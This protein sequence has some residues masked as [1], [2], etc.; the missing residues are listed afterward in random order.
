MLG[1][2]SG[3][4]DQIVRI[5]AGG[6][7]LDTRQGFQLVRLAGGVLQPVA[8]SPM[9]PELA[10]NVLLPPDCEATGIEIVPSVPETIRLSA[11]LMPCP[12]P[13]TVGDGG[14][15][16]AGTM[17]PAIHRAD[18]PYPGT[19]ARLTGQGCMAGYRFASVAVSPVQYIE[20]EQALLHYPSLEIRIKTRSTAPGPKPAASRNQAFRRMAGNMAANP[21][22]LARYASG[23][24]GRPAGPVTLAPPGPDDPYDYLI[25]TSARLAPALAPL[26]RWK[27]EKG[28]RTRIVLADSIAA[29]FPGADPAERVRACI[30]RERERCGISW[31]LLAG[32]IDDVPHR[33]AA[34]YPG[35]LYYSDLDG[36]WNLDGDGT[37]GEPEDGVDLYPD[38][39]VGRLPAADTI[40][41]GNAVRKIIAYERADSA[42]YQTKLLFIGA[43]LDAQTPTGQ[44]K[45]SIDAWNVAAYPNL[46]VEKLYPTTPIALGRSSVL[47]ALNNGRNLVNFS[48]HADYY[49]MGTGLRTGGGQIY[50]SD[51][52]GLRN[53]GRPAVLYAIGCYNGAFDRSCIGERF[54]SSANGAAA[55]IGCSRE[56]WFIPGLPLDGVSYRYDRAFFQALLDDSCHRLGEALAMAKALLVPSSGD[57]LMRWSQYEIN[58]LG[59]PEMPV[60]TDSVRALMLALPE[61]LVTG[62]DTI[63][64]AV[65]DSVSGQ[66]MGGATVCLSANSGAY[67]VG[68]SDAAGLARFFHDPAMADT[69][70]V[71]VT[72][73]NYRPRQTG[74]PVRPAQRHLAIAGVRVDDG[75]GNGDGVVNPGESFELALL[76]TNDGTV[77][78]DSLWLDVASHDPALACTAYA[79]VTHQ[80]LAPGDSVW[81]SA[82]PRAVV[83]ADCRDGHRVEFVVV[84]RTGHQ[85]RDSV[86]LTARGDSLALEHYALV[87]AVGDGDG[88]AED[89]ETIEL[90]AVRVGNLGSGRA[91]S[92]GSRLVP[93]SSGVEMLADSVAT[94]TV[95]PY[96]G[97][98]AAGAFRFAL[99]APGPYRF[100]MTMTGR[101]GRQWTG[102]FTLQ[103]R[104]TAPA[105]PTVATHRGGLKVEWPPTAGAVGHAV[106]RAFDDTAAGAEITPLL[107]GNSAYFVDHR[108]DPAMAGR[109]RIALADSSRCLSQLSAAASNL[110]AAGVAAGWPR[111]FG[112][113][114]GWNWNSPAAGDLDGDGYREVVMADPAGVLQAWDRAGTPLPGWPRPFPPSIN[115]P[116]ALADLDGDQALE[117]LVAHGDALSAVGGDGGEL[118]GWPHNAGAPLAAPVVCDLDRDGR[119]EVLAACGGDQVLALRWDGA[120]VTELWRWTLPIGTGP[121]LSVGNVRGGSLPEIIV[122]SWAYEGSRGY[123]LDGQGTAV[124][125]FWSPA[126]GDNAMPA[127]ALL[128]DLDGDDANEI[129][130]SFLVGGA[131][132]AWR[133]DGTP[134]WRAVPGTAWGTPAGV[135]VDGSPR[136]VATTLE[137][138]VHHL[139]NA[140]SAV[141]GWPA[142]WRAMHAAPAVSDLDGD[143]RGDLLLR[144][145]YG[146]ITALAAAGGT[147]P[148]FPIAT[149]DG[150]YSPVTVARL[151]PGSVGGL[152]ADTRAGDV[153]LWPAGGP[154]AGPADWPVQGHDVHRGN[155]H[156]ALVDWCG[157][158]PRSLTI[159]GDNF[160]CG[161]VVVDSGATV[162]VRSGA[163]LYF[164]DRRDFDDLGDDPQRAELVVRGRLVVAGTADDSVY[165]DT[166]SGTPCDSS[167]HG[168]RVEPGGSAELAHCGIRHSLRGLY[169]AGAAGN[170][171]T[172]AATAGYRL[173]P[174][175]P[176]PFARRTAI[177]FQL[178][179]AGKVE[180]SVYNIAGQRVR[181]LVDGSLAA[182]AHTVTW[183]GND[184][185]GATAS[186]GVYVVR[187]KVGSYCDVRKIVLLR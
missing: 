132:C 99:T 13:A 133:G 65:R 162:T 140:G 127:P 94:G 113:A 75:T 45:D 122:T 56:A 153:F 29:A 100:R 39:F 135:T 62:P 12:A 8:G 42:G 51:A 138:Y 101:A 59:D 54:L 117:V 165:C 80:P 187:I 27:T 24:T 89:G 52:A 151:A 173:Q 158:V 44:I 171:A 111:S 87:E 16:A 143:G 5:G 98:T 128:L 105:A 164:S 92:V 109:Y 68:V 25:V 36:D 125:S 22:N 49:T 157:H 69:L 31:V 64:V 104:P 93:L 14:T 2:G 86:A 15:M 186:S 21:A 96:G 139:D 17:V 35:D 32:D 76:L 145:D 58:L 160:L 154:A 106:F 41:A 152:L 10:R 166:W 63:D 1:T 28:V 73:R 119:L 116:V 81:V 121:K 168:I 95:P 70:R 85:L 167:W 102:D 72:A 74:I 118:P 18:R 177:G 107:V 131:V 169:A 82:A 126:S 144:G 182:G 4:A 112:Y 129:V 115:G 6:L 46:S 26:A 57:G 170:P 172:G 148:A 175:R 60:W 185:R 156:G 179:Q 77:A 137:G 47:A 130:A 146:D 50:P 163:R 159:A 40:A 124:D 110:P 97:T 108:P 67:A 23:A 9:V 53:V 183:T 55:F 149:Q 134:L 174:A 33:V 78:A 114:D 66:P 150:N 71:T 136:I 30:R 48:D 90:A 103:Q 180:L 20:A 176:N 3:G 19:L 91:D 147:L 161:D 61:S 83:A 84:S 7:R 181:T 178:P 155:R 88:R 142:Y 120:A 11:P 37:W 123:V 141:P 79:I 38:V 184:Q 43:D 34:G